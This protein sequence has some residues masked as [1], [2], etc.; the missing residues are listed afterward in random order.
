MT[1]NVTRWPS[2]AGPVALLM[3]MLLIW[4]QPVARARHVAAP[5]EWPP[6]KLGVWKLETTRVLP[7]GKKKH[8]TESARACT[9]G[10]DIFMGYWGGGIVEK[11]GCEYHPVR[12]ASDTFKITTVCM[13]RGAPPSTGTADV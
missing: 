2:P 3:G 7:T 13:I 12:L 6:I 1:S 9:D 8:R 11:E 5:A 4:H 10:G